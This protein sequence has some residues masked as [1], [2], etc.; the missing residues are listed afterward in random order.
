MAEFFRPSDRINIGVTL[1][2]AVVAVI[3]NLAWVWSAAAIIGVALIFEPFLKR[4]FNMTPAITLMLVC[5][6]GLVVGAVWQIIAYGFS[7]KI[8]PL[9]PAISQQE[10]LLSQANEPSSIPPPPDESKL[11][12]NYEGAIAAYRLKYDRARLTLRDLFHTDFKGTQRICNRST[13]TNH[14]TGQIALVW[15]CA[16]IDLPTAN[17]FVAIYVPFYS[18]TAGACEAILANIPDVLKL[19]SEIKMEGKPTGSTRIKSSSD[20]I[21]S[22]VAII[23]NENELSP[24]LIGDLTRLYE[25]AGYKLQFR[26]QAYLSYKKMQM[27]AGQD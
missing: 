2:L 9:Q 17:K 5:I 27:A 23:Y 1:L 24:E 11:G 20:A 26:S 14:A 22:G 6:A 13:L 3:A 18:D 7:W 19:S 10:H 4:R 21:F 15:I 12:S 16:I 8:S 25:Q